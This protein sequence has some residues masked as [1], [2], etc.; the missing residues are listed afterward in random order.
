LLSGMQLL[1]KSETV[2]NPTGGVMNLGP[3]RNLW[4]SSSLQV[5]KHGTYCGAKEALIP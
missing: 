1:T 3:M 2:T 4:E 5:V